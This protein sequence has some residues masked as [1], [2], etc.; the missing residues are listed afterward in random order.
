MADDSHDSEGHTSKIAECIADKDFCWAPDKDLTN[1]DEKREG[2]TRQGKLP[3]PH[4]DRKSASDEW[5]HEIEREEMLFETC[6]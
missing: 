4:Q 2:R 5:N 1:L 3:V 6:A